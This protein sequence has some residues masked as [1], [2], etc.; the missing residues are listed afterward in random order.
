MQIKGL[1]WVGVGTDSFRATVE[2][3]TEVLG[4]KIALSDPRGVAMLH[5]GDGQVL[6]IFGPGTS[7]R[8]RTAQPVVAFEV[9]DVI[10]AKEELLAHDVELIGDVGSWN[11]FEWLYF[12][13]P[14][15]HVYAIKK[16]PPAG[17]DERSS[18]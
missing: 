12:R 9:D 17:W 16:T 4:L 13:G 14:D 5:L 1:S 10:A 6:E 7:G 3:F 8:D 15:S 18:G 2:F 11:G